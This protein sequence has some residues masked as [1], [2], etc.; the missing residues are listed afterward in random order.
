MRIW[1]GLSADA[2]YTHL[3]VPGNSPVNLTSATQGS[4]S[5]TFD[6]SVDIVTLGLKYAF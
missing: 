2:A 6:S 3:F 4:V 1:Q 5:G